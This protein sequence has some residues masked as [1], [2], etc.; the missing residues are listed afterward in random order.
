[1]PLSSAHLRRLADEL[2]AEEKA[3]KQE[4]AQAETAEERAEIRDRLEKLEARN[5]ELE[6]QLADREAPEPEPDEDEPEPDEDPAEKKPKMRRGRRR[7]QLYQD[8]PG[9]AGYV[10]QGEDEPDLVPVEQEDAA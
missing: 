10:Y 8:R 6:T 5:A 9:E 4:L 3:E 7:G 2:D 1:M